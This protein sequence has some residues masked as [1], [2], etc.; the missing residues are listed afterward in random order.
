MS[1][2]FRGPFYWEQEDDSW[3]PDTIDPA[4][5][6]RA[7]AD[8]EPFPMGGEPLAWDNED[9]P[10]ELFS[11]DPGPSAP[12]HEALPNEH[13]ST[14]NYSQ[15][16]SPGTSLN[17]L[18]DD[19]ARIQGPALGVDWNTNP[20]ASNF[21]GIFFTYEGA[22]SSMI[23]ASSCGINTASSRVNTDVPASTPPNAVHCPFP[24]CGYVFHSGDELHKHTSSSHA[25]Q[26]LIV[27]EAPFKC[28]CGQ[29]FAK[30]YTLE[31]HIRGA[32]KHLVPEYPCH[33]CTA[34]QAKNGFKRKDHLVQH[35]RVFHKY[36]DS[37]LATLFQPR[38]AR[39][40]NIPACHIENCEYY[41]SPEFK[42]LP[43][44][45]QNNNRPFDKQSDYTSHMKQEHDWS[46]HPCNVQ[47][48]SKVG[49]KGFFSATALEKHGKEKH[50]GNTI[51]VKKKSQPRIAKRVKC[52]YCL[53]VLH[54][55]SLAHHEK[56][57]CEGKAECENCHKHMKRG[58]LLQHRRS[59]CRG[60]A[61][62]HGES[63][64]SL[65]SWVYRVT[66]ATGP[67]KELLHRESK[68]QHVSQ[69]G[70]TPTIEG[71]LWQYVP[72]VFLRLLKACWLSSKGE[73]KGLEIR[74]HLVNEPGF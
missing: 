38:Q 55:G 48:C 6:L 3:V 33:E 69:T 9:F 18:E 44:G 60:E 25:G 54:V 36:D 52:D 16:I 37:R 53:K 4:L 32:E 42:D 39:R 8:F 35:L 74:E 7:P 66:T 27:S 29:E 45:Q 12:G 64:M 13:T 73:A 30:L 65:L 15:F 24:T 41:R 47:S 61:L 56:Y 22:E 71:V 50:P 11:S 72:R 68:M 70:G 49:G 43:I 34:Y 1:D 2:N 5:L 57:Y 46:P 62:L 59:A 23:E 20:T 10:A 58:E 67:S 63:G 21:D 51:P 28:H 14:S 26:H 40:F 31:R 19:A 17:Q